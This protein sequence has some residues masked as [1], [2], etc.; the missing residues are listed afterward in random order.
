[1]DLINEKT[2]TEPKELKIVSREELKKALD[3]VEDLKIDIDLHRLVN[4]LTSNKYWMEISS[5]K[6]IERL[7]IIL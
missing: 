1:M 5:E 7:R 6:R 2:K 3:Q 4:K